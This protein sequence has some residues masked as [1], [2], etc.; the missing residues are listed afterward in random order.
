MPETDHDDFDT[1]DTMDELTVFTPDVMPPKATE[2]GAH[3]AALAA[4]KAINDAD[5][6]PAQPLGVAGGVVKPLLGLKATMM[7]LDEG[8]FI[9]SAPPVWPQA[10]QMPSALAWGIEE[11]PA[12][13]TMVWFDIEGTAHTMPAPHPTV[14]DALEMGPTPPATQGAPIKALSPSKVKRAKARA[15]AKASDSAPAPGAAVP[16]APTTRTSIFGNV[17][18]IEP[19]NTWVQYEGLGWVYT[20]SEASAF[21]VTYSQCCLTQKWHPKIKVAGATRGRTVSPKAAAD[22]GW[23]QCAYS[24]SWS[25]P[26]DAT[27]A[28]DNSNEQVKVSIWVLEHNGSSLQKCEVYG[29]PFIPS[30]IA[31]LK[32]T[33]G[34]YKVVSNHALHHSDLFHQCATCSKWDE[35]EF[36]PVRSDEGIAGS[37]VCTKCH[38][39]HLK[40]NVILKHNANNYPK[41]IYDRT[42]GFDIDAG[43]WTDKAGRMLRLFGVEVE[44]EMD[45]AACKKA[46][47][48]RVDLALEVRAALGTDFQITKEDGTLRMNG[49]YS[50]QGKDPETNQELDPNGT[51][52]TYAGFEIVSAPCDLATHRARWPRLASMPH[53]K[54]LRAWDTETC[55]FHVHVSKETLTRLQVCRIVAFIN[56]PANL[57]LI[58]KVAG[59]GQ[60][61]WARYKE[62][63]LSDGLYPE[64][65][66]S[67]SEKETYNRSRR[68]AINL[69]NPKT[70]EFRLFRGT[71][72]VADKEGRPGGHMMRNIEFCDAVCEFCAPSVRSFSTLSADHFVRFIDQNRK[73]WSI[74]A[75][76]MAHHEMIEPSKIGPKTDIGRLTIRPDTTPEPEI[77]VV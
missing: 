46:K 10:V 14:A 67:E 27:L 59:R 65:V 22:A 69:A 13:D 64:R 31:K 66:I 12:K 34:K 74:L 11:P 57:N 17:Y 26:E 62:K 44:T 70:V 73:R 60:H 21:S 28:F 5:A 19:S 41:P 51:G 45:L 36:V 37:P 9:T 6:L 24:G 2:Q 1:L 18:P 20:P 71:I 56:D 30:A 23:F 53:F 4:L 7:T 50:G 43:V 40:E 52:P 77:I 49:K 54:V 76:W 48:T 25:N 42:T 3:T 16:V 47:V 15:K 75:T 8:P 55:G 39:K 38:V 63:T 58:Q 29:T 61:R 35:K 33:E 32:A 72:N 68:V